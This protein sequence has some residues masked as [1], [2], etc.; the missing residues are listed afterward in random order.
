MVLDKDGSDPTFT[1]KPLGSAGDCCHIS[2]RHLIMENER[3]RMRE[4]G[5]VLKNINS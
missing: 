4:G 5:G 1:T 3:G 2:T